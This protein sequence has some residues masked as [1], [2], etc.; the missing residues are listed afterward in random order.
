MFIPVC[1]CVF[2]CLFEG[3][4]TGCGCPRDQ[5]LLRDVPQ[6]VLIAPLAPVVPTCL[7]LN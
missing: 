5:Q 1:V 2:V 7:R 6:G 3:G 4:V